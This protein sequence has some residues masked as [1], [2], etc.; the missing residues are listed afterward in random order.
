MRRLGFDRVVEHDASATLIADS[1]SVR[2]WTCYRDGDAIEVVRWEWP[3]KGLA[4]YV[5][6]PV[7]AFKYPPLAHVLLKS[8][9]A[10]LARL[11]HHRGRLEPLE[12]RT[13][14]MARALELRLV[15]MR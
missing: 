14:D 12:P 8:G 3:D 5:I 4:A 11:D 9:Q 15:G 13:T 7:G 6:L 1:Q 10:G 2:W